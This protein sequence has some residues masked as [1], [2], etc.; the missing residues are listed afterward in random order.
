[1]TEPEAVILVHGLWVPGVVMALLQRRIGRC[2]YRTLN[3]TYPSM[4]R[5]LTE[6]AERLARYCRGIGAARLNFVGHSMGGLVVLTMLERPREFA[7]GRIVLAGTPYDGS[8]AARSLARLP[9]GRTALGSCLPEWLGRERPK[10]PSHYEVGV[11]AGK[12]SIGLGR[13]VAPGMARPN[14]GVV[15]VSETRLPEMHDHIV[16]DVNHTGM[17]L[18]RTVARQICEF[19]RHGAFAKE[20]FSPP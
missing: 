17:L 12:L 7:I 15:S 9:G 14:D 3:Y 16:L 11:I 19:L 18:S 20:S 10:L 8:V 13:L 6:N 2:G 5:T 1:M 4:R